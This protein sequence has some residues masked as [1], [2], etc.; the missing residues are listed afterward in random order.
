[1]NHMHIRECQVE[2]WPLRT[3]CRQVWARLLAEI[4]AAEPPEDVQNAVYKLAS[5]VAKNG[6]RA[7]VHMCWSLPCQISLSISHLFL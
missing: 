2:S 5:Y 6:V 4:M 7:W 3:A 1:M